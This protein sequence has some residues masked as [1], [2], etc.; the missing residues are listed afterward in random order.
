MKLNRWE[1][2]CASTAAVLWREWPL[3]RWKLE[4]LEG[5]TAILGSRRY[6]GSGPGPPLYCQKA[7][8]QI[9][10]SQ[11]AHKPPYTCK[12]WEWWRGKAQCQLVLGDPGTRAT[13]RIGLWKPG[14]P[15]LPV[16]QLQGIILAPSDWWIASP[17]VKWST[18]SVVPPACR[19]GKV[20]P[21]R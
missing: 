5:L 6:S 15:W 14:L 7:V 3:H 16:A 9:L 11:T 4:V 20:G 21:R 1:D 2:G 12:P 8:A 10:I 18:T 13:R 17:G 19:Q